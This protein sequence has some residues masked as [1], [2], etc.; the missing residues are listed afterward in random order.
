LFNGLF[1][2]PGLSV[3][4][5]AGPVWVENCFIEGMPFLIVQTPAAAQVSNCASVTFQRCTLEGSPGSNSPNQTDGAHG[6]Q[7]IASSVS[8][9]DGGMTGGKGGISFFL[10]FGGRNGGDG[11]RFESG[12]LF[13]TGTACAG[14]DGGAGVN[15]GGGGGNGITVG[16]TA[17]AL[18]CGFS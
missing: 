6:L 2:E 12:E 9:A 13:M 3:K 11:V 15:I 7:V 5:N 1:S 16:G 17:Y 8:V 4:N 18:D 14:G 10:S